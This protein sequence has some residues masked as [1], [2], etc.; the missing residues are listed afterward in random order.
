VSTEASGA[1]SG[2][3]HESA[4]APV[5]G[6]GSGNGAG[7]SGASGPGAGASSGPGN[8]DSSGPFGIGTGV[9]SGEGP[10]HIVYLL[11]IS[12]SMESRIERAKQELNDALAGLGQDE[13]FNVV[14]FAGNT[15][16][17]M[18][19]LVPDTHAWTM[20]AGGFLDTLQL[21]EGTNLERALSE[22]LRMDG[23]NVV[24]VLTDGVPTVGETDFKKL[25]RL[26]RERNK[27]HARIYTIGLVGKDPDGR[28]ESFDATQLLQQIARDSGGTCKLVSLG[29]AMM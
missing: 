29:D 17:F 10:R 5:T 20:K 25:A 26:I 14:A 27:A 28:D 24:V 16:P 2:T 1:P 12:L 21:R 23:V 3:S 4:G 6:V 13:S 11:D 19:R 15:Q 8:G 9:G 7:G 18:D 22:A